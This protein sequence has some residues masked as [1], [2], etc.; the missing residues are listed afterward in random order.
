M[1]NISEVATYLKKE[2]S[3]LSYGNWFSKI[4]QDP[5]RK[6]DNRIVGKATI[7]VP[8]VTCIEAVVFCIA[9][10]FILKNKEYEQIL[11]VFEC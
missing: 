5:E 4:I 9:I 1:R 2:K 11:R 8:Y 6:A 10:H 3:F 7:H